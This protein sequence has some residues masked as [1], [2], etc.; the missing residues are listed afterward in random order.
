MFVIAVAHGFRDYR[1][2]YDH[3]A[4]LDLRAARPDP[5]ILFPGDEV[6]IPDRTERV[7]EASTGQRHTFHV[8][9]S[10]RVLR[11]RLLDVFDQPFVEE[12][13]QLTIDG[14]LVPGDLRTDKD[15]SLAHEIHSDARAGTIAVAAYTWSFV[16]GA[17]DPVKSTLDDGVTGV[18]G[19]LF[20]LGYDLG[21]ID[22]IAGPRTLTAV[23]E[24]QQDHLLRVTG[25]IDDVLKAAL[26]AAHG[27]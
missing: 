10:P 8:A 4:N 16:I 24:F 27:C 3:L 23:R 7:E 15:G 12:P 19:R 21:P 9:R 22:G 20:N 5:A 25:A 2:V 18:Q 14:A 11:L 1:T 17:L 6:L 13:Y 26:I